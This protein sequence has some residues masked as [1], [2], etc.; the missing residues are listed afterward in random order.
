[1]KNGAMRGLFFLPEKKGD[2]SLCKKWR[3]ICLLDVC[4]KLLSY[5]LVRRLQ[6]VMEKFGIDAQT[7]FRPDRGT[8]DGIFNTFVGLHKH[9]EHGLET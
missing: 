7:G 6:I 1:M 9:K 3:G 8:I 2:L 4:S 5:V